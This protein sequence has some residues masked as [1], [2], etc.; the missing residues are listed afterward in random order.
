MSGETRVGPLTIEELAMYPGLSADTPVWYDGLPDWTVAGNVIEI[1]LYLANREPDMTPP[2]VPDDARPAASAD[3]HCSSTSSQKPSSYMGW[4]IASMLV[5]F[6]ITGIVAVVYA[7]K[8]SPAWH[9][10]D[11]EAA[12]KAS[13]RAALWTIITFVAGLMITPFTMLYSILTM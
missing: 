7:S 8:V 10:G 3:S 11:Y 9:R 12:R 4:A 5:C 1:Q 2:P 6:T 13:D